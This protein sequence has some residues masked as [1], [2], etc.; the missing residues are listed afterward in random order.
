MLILMKSYQVFNG[1]EVIFTA[2]LWVLYD[3]VFG[4]VL[5]RVRAKLFLVLLGLEL[6]SQGI[7]KT[8]SWLTALP[9]PSRSN[10]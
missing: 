4:P 2:F 3:R 8:S 5:H 10:F 6:A 9:I 1:I 7:S